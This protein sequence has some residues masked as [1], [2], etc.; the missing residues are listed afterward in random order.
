LSLGKR[1]KA[2]AKQS[3]H[4]CSPVSKTHAFMSLR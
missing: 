2:L 3:L 1:M 4:P